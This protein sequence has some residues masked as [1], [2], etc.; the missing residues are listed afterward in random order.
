MIPQR[1]LAETYA[2]LSL[3]RFHITNTVDHA[4][5]ISTSNILVMH[6]EP[7]TWNLA[8]ELR[9]QLLNENKK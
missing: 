2:N 6:M 5:I 9:N 1:K 3:L 8:V 4:T 7:K